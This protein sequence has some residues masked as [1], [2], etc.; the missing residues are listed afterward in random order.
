MRNAPKRP[1]LSA[2]AL[3]LLALAGCQTSKHDADP[4][5]RAASKIPF[6]P[7]VRNVA[8][9][10]GEGRYPNLYTGA[11][12][13]IWDGGGAAPQPMAAAT[14]P[15]M[16]D[17]KS[18]VPKMED[19]KSEST[20]MGEKMDAAPDAVEPA[21][22]QMRR[23]GLKIECYLESEF[24]DMS[25]AYD[26]VGLRGVSIYLKLP[27]G[28]ELPPSQ[29]TLDPDLSETPVGALRRY[30]RKLTL[31]F[32]RSDFM[33]ENPA[34]NPAA[35]GIR[36]VLEGH[37]TSFYFEWHSMPNFLASTEPRIDYKVRDA[38]KRHYQSTS[39]AVKKFSH[40]FD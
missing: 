4:Y 14:P 1:L 13:A 37:A 15:A 9:A 3:T 23:Q 36:L 20:A 27:D 35:N 5:P 30:G 18:A 17:E 8:I 29:T 12:H 11:S 6:A 40:N 10:A 16:M 21:G 2:V 25:I 31:Y 19:K 7:T 28:Q 32:P 26:A 24:P 34:A 33:V 22:P 39:G 38:G